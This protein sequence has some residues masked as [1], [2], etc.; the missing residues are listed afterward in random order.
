MSTV[1]ASNFTLL[2]IKFIVEKAN[3]IVE[4]GL[5]LEKLDEQ[6]EQA[7]KYNIYYDTIPLAMARAEYL[8]QHDE[9]EFQ[10]VTNGNLG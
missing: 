6:I 7:R 9:A 2:D 1:N 8:L 3:T 4:Q 5:S 10:E